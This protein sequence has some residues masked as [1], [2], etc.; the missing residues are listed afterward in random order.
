MTTKE[1]FATYEEYMEHKIKTAQTYVEQCAYKDALK[2]YLK[3]K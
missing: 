1:A 3:M 2:A